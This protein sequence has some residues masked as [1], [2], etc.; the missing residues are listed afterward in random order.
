M[1]KKFI[2]FGIIIVAAAAVIYL[3]LQGGGKP[4]DNTGNVNPGADKSADKNV[5]N[6][7]KTG[8]ENNMIIEE[9]GGNPVFAVITT[10]AGVI[11]VQLDPK[12]T[13]NTVA[14]FVKLAR[15]GFYDGVKFHRVISGFM[16]QG[17]DPL[18]KDD[19]KK[20]LWG[21][22]GPGYT[23]ADEPFTGEYARGTMA[24]AN[25]GPNTNGS[26]FF[27]MHKDYPLQKDYVI[28]GRVVEG[29][30]TVDK[31]AETKTDARDCPLEPMVIDSIV[32][33]Q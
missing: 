29:L 24:M 11:K 5:A 21:T 10:S 2:I 4:E 18:T 30:E 9:L 23:F 20:N 26:Q 8:N 28:F 3:I 27:I 14:N 25:A 7:S 12:S 15:Q 33:A 32:I 16:I 6:N 22:G 31:I 19:S 13:P 1:N 17:G